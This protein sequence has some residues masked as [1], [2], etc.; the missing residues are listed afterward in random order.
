MNKSDLPNVCMTPVLED[1]SDR[2]RL[3]RLIAELKGIT[4]TDQHPIVFNGVKQA[5]E[6]LKVNSRFAE[7]AAAHEASGGLLQHVFVGCFRFPSLNSANSGTKL[8]V[9]V[10]ESVKTQLGK[11]EL[12]IKLVLHKYNMC[13]S[14]KLQDGDGI[15]TAT[16]IS[17]DV[18][19]VSESTV[20]QM[21]NVSLLADGSSAKYGNG[22]YM[23][24]A[25]DSAS[26][27]GMAAGLTCVVFVRDGETDPYANRSL[28]DALCLDMV[29]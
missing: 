13:L 28:S 3:K 24:K 6:L 14:A 15:D 7:R 16:A 29:C 23:Q 20:L 19:A 17:I 4:F 8:G 9:H 1:G 2:Q 22:I 10:S 21:R 26:A 18:H 11:K 27:S 5:E 12:S 25:K